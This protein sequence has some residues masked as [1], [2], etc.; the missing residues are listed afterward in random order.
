[1]KRDSK[2]GYIASKL[3]A[4]NKLAEMKKYEIHS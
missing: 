4:S 2:E 3:F 1:M